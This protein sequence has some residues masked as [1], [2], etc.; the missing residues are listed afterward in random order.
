MFNLK[1]NGNQ[2]RP[3]D[4]AMKLQYPIM[5]AIEAT[6]PIYKALDSIRCGLCALNIPFQYPF[7]IH[8]HTH[9][10]ASHVVDP[11]ITKYGNSCLINLPKTVAKA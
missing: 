8:A 11:N 2:C 5:E 3:I 7:K 4:S 10:F 1:H 6:I 9:T